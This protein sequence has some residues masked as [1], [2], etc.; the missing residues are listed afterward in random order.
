MM[1]VMMHPFTA[2]LIVLILGY[3]VTRGVISNKWFRSRPKHFVMIVRHHGQDFKSFTGAR[4]RRDAET[5][6]YQEICQQIRE[7]GFDPFDGEM[8]YRL[9]DEA[10][11][12]PLTEQTHKDEKLL[13]FKPGK[14]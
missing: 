7:A 10:L 4:H 2:F 5:E 9:F 12:K 13:V 6:L 11:P 14:R 1:E 8:E 3:V